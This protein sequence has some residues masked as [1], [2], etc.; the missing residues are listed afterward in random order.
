MDRSKT[1]LIDRETQL[2]E[3]EDGTFG[4]IKTPDGW[5]CYS[6]ELPWRGNQQRISCI[7]EGE[8][9]LRL[10]R[11]GII[12]RTTRRAKKKGH[13]P[14]MLYGY[15]IDEVE[16]RDLI[17]LHIA[18]HIG[19]LLGCVGMGNGRSAWYVSEFEQEMPAVTQSTRTFYQLM[20]HIEK[21][22][23]NRAL[24]GRAVPA[25]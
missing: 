10:R 23:C 4:R 12:E 11:S 13:G 21:C 5:S 22:G 19:H 6:V 8:Y 9:P 25:R 16:G 24:I 18:N 7:P 2:G 14:I 17:M 1:L 15:E 20:S 3:D